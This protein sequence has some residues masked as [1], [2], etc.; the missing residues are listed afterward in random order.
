MLHIHNGESSAEILRQSGLPGEHFA[1]REALISGPTPAGVEGAAWLSLRA[2]HLSDS[3]GVEPAK[4]ERELLE[5]E[6]LLA[7]CSRQDE[8]VLWFEHDLFC[9]TNLLYLLNRLSQTEPGN[10]I[11]SLI[12]IGE[13]PGIIAFRGL[14]QLTIEQLAG[15][16]PA[17]QQ[18][19]SLQ[20][21]LAASAWAAYRAA[22]PTRIASLLE[23]DTSA[24]PFVAP[25]LRSHLTR[26]PSVA[27][28]LGRIEQHG[29][30]LI[31]GGLRKFADLF[32]AFGKAEPE[33]GL[34]DFQFWLAL[35]NLAKAQKPLLT[36]SHV[37]LAGNALNSEALRETHIELTP[38]GAAILNGKDDFIRMNGIDLWLGGVHLT[39]EGKIWRWNEKEQRLV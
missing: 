35:R 3:Y 14:G 12:C 22:D 29:L 39:N 19:T 17:R 2:K 1:F 18:V 37:A 6:E 34:G 26:F 9:Q 36:M 31:T 28:G 38:A 27:N 10:T 33:F 11:L 23:S 5:Q 32:S 13:F 20:L 4:C 21:N 30:E 24:L 25:A 15:L 7:N 16:F 8:V